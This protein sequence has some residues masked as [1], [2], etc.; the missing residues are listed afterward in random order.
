MTS[1]RAISA[2][3]S[4]A[5]LDSATHELRPRADDRG[6]VLGAGRDRHESGAGAQRSLAGHARGAR[7]ADAAADHEH[8]ALLALVSRAPA[9]RQQLRNR[10]LVDAVRLRRRRAPTPA[11]ADPSSSNMT[12]PTQFGSLAE[13]EAELESD[14]RE[15]S[16]GAHRGA[17]N[18]AGVGVQAARNVE[19]EHGRAAAR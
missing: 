7:H 2:V 6:D 5:R 11:A 4:S 10:D 8:T 14:E 3:K 9:P 17:E 1:A 19:R 12:T 13:I 16:L 15:R 18:L